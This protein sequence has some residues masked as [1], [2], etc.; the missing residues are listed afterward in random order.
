MKLSVVVSRILIYLKS[1]FGRE[2]FA[3]FLVPSCELNLSIVC[4]KLGVL[5]VGI[6]DHEWQEDKR[7][8]SGCDVRGSGRF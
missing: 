7:F 1:K 2:K 6:R 5:K 8:G 3:R 4:D